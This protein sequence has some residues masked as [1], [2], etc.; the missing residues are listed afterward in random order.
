MLKAA[1]AVHVFFPSEA[2]LVRKFAPRAGCFSVPTGASG[3]AGGGVGGGGYVAWFGRYDPE[4]KGLTRLLDGWAEIT[5]EPAD[6][7]HARDRLSEWTGTI[8]RAGRPAGS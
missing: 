8:A 3:A 7:A 1:T 5:P 6:A 4:H 2:A